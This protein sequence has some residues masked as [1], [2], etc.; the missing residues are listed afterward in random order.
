MLTFSQFINESV[1]FQVSH[2]DDTTHHTFNVGQHTVTVKHFISKTKKGTF[3]DTDFEVN[4]KVM[5]DSDNISQQHVVKILSGVGQSIKKIK[6]EHHTPNKKLEFS[7]YGNTEQKE[8]VYKMAAKRLA[9][10]M[11]GKVRHRDQTSYLTFKE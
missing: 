11:G 1:D 4:G 2:E 10:Q 5:K 9:R 8:N 7:M 3:V 6:D